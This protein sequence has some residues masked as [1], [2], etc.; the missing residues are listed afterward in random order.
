M[1]SSGVPSSLPEQ[2]GRI[3][4][5]RRCGASLIERPSL[6]VPVM[7]AGV[8]SVSTTAFQKWLTHRIV[9]HVAERHSV[10][11]SQ[12]EY[13]TSAP[14]ILKAAVA[15]APL[16]W[17]NYLLVIFLFASA[18]LVTAA[19]VRSGER[20]GFRIDRAM[21]R[22]FMSRTCLVFSAKVLAVFAILIIIP[23]ALARSV[24][25]AF[26]ATDGGLMLDG[27]IMAGEALVIAPWALVLLVRPP[28]RRLPRGSA[29]FARLVAVGT[30]LISL[31]LGLSIVRLE[32]IV[33]VAEPYLSRSAAQAML[34]SGQIVAVV[35]YAALFVCL[36]M[37]ADLPQ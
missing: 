20:Q 18:L 13:D 37:L 22:S 34:Y 7:L 25:P 36:T 8:A 15:S 26:F 4:A 19:M 11:S 30:V 28:G 35:P 10:L 31:G 21:V 3:D 9:L 14:A 32:Q 33:W 16:V 2:Y 12:V 17:G 6:L 5:L 23:I 29:T 24:S 27:L 1:N